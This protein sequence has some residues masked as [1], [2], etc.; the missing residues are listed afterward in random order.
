MRKY[1]V[2]SS[3]V[4][5]AN[6]GASVDVF[7]AVKAR[8][9]DAGAAEAW[10]GIGS[11]LHILRNGKIYESLP[12]FVN[13]AAFTSLRAIA[14]KRDL[15][16]RTLA[17]YA[18]LYRYIMFGDSEAAFLAASVKALG[19][20]DPAGARGQWQFYRDYKPFTANLELEENRVRYMQE[21]NMATGTQREIIPYSRIADMSVARDA[22]KLLG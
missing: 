19:K 6:V 16:V 3:K 17:A 14:Q 21:L 15:L 13:Q 5:F 11:D 1:G 2:D 18:K 4:K 10:L 22:L 12:E 7:K 9:V 20:N 8:V